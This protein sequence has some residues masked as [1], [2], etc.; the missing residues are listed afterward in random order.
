[1]VV[2]SF[3]ERGFILIQ[4]MKKTSIILSI[5]AI[6]ASLSAQTIKLKPITQLRYCEWDS[7]LVTY[8]ASDGFKAGNTFTVQLSDAS[9]SFSSFTN[10][11]TLT[12]PT[13]SV[14]VPLPNAGSGF[15]VRVIS[16]EPYIVSAENDSDIV[17]TIY[18][19][20]YPY[21]T[22]LN[23]SYEPALNGGYLPTGSFSGLEG[24]PIQ[25]TDGE[26]DYPGGYTYSWVFNEDA[27]PHTSTD[28]API[29]TYPTSGAKDGTLT[30]T[31]RGG[32]SASATFS[33]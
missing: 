1:M 21:Y 27:S 7:V 3:Y 15:R 13:G 14:W 24:D 26:T 6:S 32:C 33:F 10:E 22:P 17:V 18:A 4:I 8:I 5:L 19:N 9:G 25:F 29:V 16:T 11:G 12:T 28:K 30:S 31:Y 20:P 23:Q 2:E